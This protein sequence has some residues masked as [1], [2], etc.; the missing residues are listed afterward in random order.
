MT[1]VVTI[2]WQTI[3]LCILSHIACQSHKNVISRIIAA[4]YLKVT[5]VEMSEKTDQQKETEYA[6][7]STIIH[8]NSFGLC[9]KVMD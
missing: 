3:T 2:L 1:L 4:R 7:I 8:H 5:T 6:P 9:G